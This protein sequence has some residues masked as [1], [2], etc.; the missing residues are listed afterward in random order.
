MAAPKKKRGRGTGNASVRKARWSPEKKLAILTMYSENYTLSEIA[1]STGVPANSISQ[2][3]SATYKGL[4]NSRQSRQLKMGKSKTGEQINL[5]EEQ[6]E[7]IQKT[8]DPDIINKEFYDRVSHPEAEELTEYEVRFCWSFVASQD[9]EEA[10][11]ISELDVGLY[12]I[13]QVKGGI[14]S[15]P[16]KAYNQNLR[17]R[18]A[19]LKSKKNIMNFIF[20]I[21]REVVLSASVDKHFLQREIMIQI[22]NLKNSTSLEAKKLLKSYIEMLGKTF[23]GFSESVAVGQ[24]DHAETLKKL[25]DSAKKTETLQM[26]IAAKRAEDIVKEEEPPQVH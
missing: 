3:V 18:V 25:H 2:F 17:I 7:E 26:A 4:S 24:I 11:K 12:D 21:Q 10:M 19:Y 20:K 8:A 22:D 13:E 5:T 1:L 9:Y 16:T 14:S 23:G 6:Q 15:K